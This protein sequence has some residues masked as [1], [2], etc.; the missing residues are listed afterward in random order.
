ML[1]VQS[2]AQFFYLNLAIHPV[3]QHISL[4]SV[5]HSLNP[6][7]L[8]TQAQ[9]SYLHLIIHPVLQDISILSVTR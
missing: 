9:V 4:L 1:C 6:K 2:Q 7:S 8:Q 5:I 3:L